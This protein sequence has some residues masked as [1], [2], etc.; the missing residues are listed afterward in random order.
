[1]K[2]KCP[3]CGRKIS[4]GTRFMERIYGE[5]VCKHCKKP[6]NIVQDNKLWGVFA[7]VAV[8]SLLILIFYFIFGNVMQQEYNANG[9]HEFFI[10]LF[11]GKFK[12]LKWVLWETIPYIAFFFVSPLFIKYQ[13]QKKYA[14]MSSEF[15]DLGTDFLPPINDAENGNTSGTRVIPKVGVN[16]VADDYDFENISSSSK[17]IS[18]TRNFSIKSDFT[19][20]NPENYVKSS[21]Y[22]SETPLRKMEHTQP[23]RI[24]EE[25]KAEENELYRVKVLREQERQ[26]RE[27]EAQAK[28]MDKNNTDKNYSANRRF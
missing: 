8:F 19:K 28:E 7:G 25:I 12:T 11:F 20:I 16:K 27:L 13:M 24:K 1:M 3:Y 23:V 6:S 15:I 14:Y 18:D 17:N 22:R 9:D 2:A 4:Y 5:H 26:K 10:T 21:S